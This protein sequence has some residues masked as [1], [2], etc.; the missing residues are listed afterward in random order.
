MTIDE[1]E[2]DYGGVRKD[3][4]I[5]VLALRTAPRRI[6]FANPEQDREA[7]ELGETSVE[8]PNASEASRR[9][10]ATVSRTSSSSSWASFKQPQSQT[11]QAPALILF[12]RTQ[13]SRSPTPPGSKTGWVM[14]VVKETENVSGPGLLLQNFHGLEEDSG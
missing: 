9:F 14:V 7:E 6:H 5:S 4:P 10:Y 12:Y 11:R 1:D 3:A 8:V 13:T 2:I